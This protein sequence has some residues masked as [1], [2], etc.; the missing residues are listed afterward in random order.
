[1]NRFHLQRTVRV[2]FLNI[3]KKNLWCEPLLIKFQKALTNLG[4]FGYFDKVGSVCVKDVSPLLMLKV[5]SYITFII[6]IIII[7]LF[8]TGLIPPLLLTHRVSCVARINSGI[9][10]IDN[11]Q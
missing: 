11:E 4:F 9:P 1:V 2:Q 6:I 10:P 7:S 5:A 8:L 3:V